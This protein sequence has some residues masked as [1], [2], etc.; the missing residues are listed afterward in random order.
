MRKFVMLL[1][2]TAAAWSAP[3]PVMKSSVATPAPGQKVDLTFHVSEDGAKLTDYE[4]VHEK[5]CHLILVSADYKD[6]Q[7]VHPV[8]DKTGTFTMKNVAFQ[9]PGR[10]YVFFDVTPEGS[11]QILKRFEVQVRGQGEPLVL[12][13]DLSKKTIG[14][15]TVA[16]EPMPMP[17][18]VGDAMLH[19]RLSQ[20]GKPVTDVKPFM[21]AMGHVVALGQGGKPFLHIHPMEGHDGHHGGHHGGHHQHEAVPGEVVFHASFPKPGLYKVWGQ[22]LRGSQMLIAP[23]TVKVV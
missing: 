5:K 13:E 19:F 3:K 22:F 14:G 18:K 10:Y 2:L 7:H 8:L 20:N 15:V 4:T 21:G 16:L 9:R 23:F 17:L 12:K 1:M 11:Q 6:F